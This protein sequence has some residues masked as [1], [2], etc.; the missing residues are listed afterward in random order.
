M[1]LSYFLVE[2]IV[3]NMWNHIE[4]FKCG[5]LIVLSKLSIIKWFVHIVKILKT[6]NGV[7][8]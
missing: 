2:F 4:Y 6:Q 7:K 5:I 1:C 8:V 3:I